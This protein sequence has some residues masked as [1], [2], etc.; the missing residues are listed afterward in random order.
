[1]EFKHNS[2]ETGIGANERCLPHSSLVPRVQCHPRVL[3]FHVKNR[4]ICGAI[5]LN[6]SS[7]VNPK[8]HSLLQI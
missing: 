8:H 2:M 5:K 1:M 4:S 3:E 6:N 7:S